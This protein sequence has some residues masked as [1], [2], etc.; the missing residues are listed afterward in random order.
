MRIRK[1]EK[2]QRMRRFTRRARKKTHALL[3]ARM[4]MALS[5]LT[6]SHEYKIIVLG[7][8][9]VLLSSDTQA[10]VRKREE[11]GLQVPQFL[12]G[13]ATAWTVRKK[14]GHRTVPQAAMMH[15][16]SIVSGN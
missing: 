8:G 13:N 3:I 4:M 6:D 11:S 2:N 5:V 12:P 1:R 7:L 16:D 15:L 10:D 9:Q 14:K